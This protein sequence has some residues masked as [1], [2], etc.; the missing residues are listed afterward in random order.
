MFKSSFFDQL[1]MM[2]DPD[3]EKKYRRLMRKRAVEYNQD[4]WWRPGEPLPRRAPEFEGIIE[5]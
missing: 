2:A 1:E 4:Y 5:D 3:A